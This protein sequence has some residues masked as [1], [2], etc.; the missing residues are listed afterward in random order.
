VNTNSWDNLADVFGSSDDLDDIPAEAA[1]N[2]LIAWPIIVDGE[3]FLQEY[4]D[5]TITEHLQKALDFRYKD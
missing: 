2:I 3:M 5:V 1:D 4:G